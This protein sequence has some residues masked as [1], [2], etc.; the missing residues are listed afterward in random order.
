VTAPGSSFQAIFNV[1]ALIRGVHSLTAFYSGDSN[2]SASWSTALSQ[3]V[4][5]QP[6]TVNLTSAPSM[7]S[8]GQS[9][10][11]TA[12]VAPFA[13]TLAP[14]GTVTFYDGATAIGTAA[15]AGAVSGSVPAVLTFAALSVGSH[16][17]SATYSG[18]NNFSS[19]N[20]NT[21]TQT[22]NQ[23]SSNTTLA[24]S[25]N[26][27]ALCQSAMFTATVTPAGSGGG[28]PTGAV[29]FYNGGTTLGTSSLSG[30]VATYSTASLPQGSNSISA[31]YAG[32]GNFLSGA[33]N[34]LTQ[35]VNAA[36]NWVMTAA[37]AAPDPQQGVRLPVGRA[38]FSPLSGT[39]FRSLAIDSNQH[40]F[41]GCGGFGGSCGCSG[42]CGCGGCGNDN[43][44]AGSVPLALVY[45][46]GTVN[47]RPIFLVNLA[48]D[49]CASVPSQIQSQLTWN[50]VPQG[51]NTFGTPGH[52]AGDVYAV[53]QQVGSAVSASDLY[54]WSV[55]VKA[56]VGTVV[57]DRTASG[58]SPVVVNTSSPFGAGWA[59]G[60]SWSLLIK[61]AG[62]VIVDNNTGGARYFTGTGPTY[63]S[64]AND[65]GSLI[66]NGDG[67]YT[68]TAKNQTKTNFDSAGRMTGQVDPHGLTQSL[69]YSGNLLTTVTGCDGGVATFS[70]N[71]SNLLTSVQEP[72]GRYLTLSYDA[73][74]NL[75]SFLDAA[76][77]PHTFAYDSSHRLVNEKVGPLNV[78]YTYSSGNSTLTQINR[79]LGTTLAVA[80]AAAQGLGASTAINASAAVAA[81]TDGL[82]HT[83][84]YAFDSLGRQTQLQTADA[85]L[86]T[87]TLDA[88]GNPTTYADQRGRV[89]TYVYNTAEDLTQV[90]YPD[91]TFATYQYETTFHQK[92]QCQDALGRL[93]TFSYD[94]MTGDL[95]TK[96]DA[97][98][99]VTTYTW[100]SGLKQTT[101]DALGHVTTMQWDSAKRRQ[102][103]LIDA[104]SHV[105]T[106]GYDGA[107]N[108]TTVQDAL[109]HVTT[110]S[111]DGNRRV[112]TRTNALGGATTYAYDAVGDLSSW[113]DPLGRTTSFGYDQRG[114]PTT[115][116]EAVGTAQQRT[117]TTTYDAAGN[118]LYTTD[119]LGDVTSYA[120]DALNR[121]TAKID[122]YGTSLQRT[123]TMVY[124]LAGNILSRIDPRGTTTSYGYDS[125]NRQ[126]QQIDAY[127]AAAQRTTTMAHDA[128]GNVTSVTNPRGT[129][130][131]FAYDADNR[132]TRRLEAYGTSLQRTTT[133]AYDA[134][135]NVQSVT[136]PTATTSYAYDPLNR[137]TQTIDG[138]GSSVQRTTTTAYDAVGNM[139][140][141]VNPRGYTTSYGYDA[142]NR[143]IQ[144]LDA[145]GTGLQRT[146]TTT[147]DA[148]GNL[149]S[150]TNGVGEVTSFAYDALNR[151]TAQL[152]GYGTSLQRTTTTAYDADDNVTATMDPLGYRTTYSY[153]ALNRRVTMRDAGGGV[154]TTAYDADDNLTAQTDPLGHTTT[155]AYDVLNRK[156][157]TTDARGGI[158]TLVY[159]PNNNLVS[160]TDPVSNLTQW[161]YD[162]LDRKLKE[163]D[164]LSYGATYAYDAADRLTSAT[165]RNGQRLAYR[166]DA[167]NRETGETWYNA[168]GTSIN[169]LT[170]TYDPNNN[171]LTA[172]NATATNT[173]AYDALD[174]KTT[175]Q[176]PFGAFLT[177]AYDAADNRTLMQ[178]SLGAN[179]TRVYDVLN[180][181]T[182]MM[183]G[184]TGQ[185]PLREDFTYTALDRTATQTRYS[186][187][188]GTTTIGDSTYGY[189]AVARLTNLQHQN[190]AGANIANYTNTYDLASRITSE[191]LNGAAPTTY[192]YD[193]TNELTSDGVTSYSY[194]LNGNRTMTGYMTGAANELTSDGTWN[195]YYDPNGNRTSSRNISTSETWQFGYDNRNRLTTAQDVTSAG[196]QTQATY[197][198]DAVGKRIEKD[199]GSGGVTTVT[200]F[201][202]DG[203]EIWADLNSSNTLMTR[204]VR[205]DRVL[206][207][208][209][210]ISGGGTAAWIQ[211]DRLGTVRHV[212]DATGAV[213]DT[214]T[215]DGYGNITN[216]T[217]AANGGVYKY[218][219]YRLDSESGWYRPD[220][221]TARYYGP[222]AGTWNGRDAL[223]LFVKA[224]NQYFYIG[225]MPTKATDASGEQPSPI[226]KVQFE[227]AAAGGECTGPDKNEFYKKCWEYVRDKII[228]EAIKEQPGGKE[229]LE[230]F[231]WVGCRT[232]TKKDLDPGELVKK[233]IGLLCKFIP[234]NHFCDLFKVGKFLEACAAAIVTGVADVVIPDNLKELAEGFEGVDCAD[235]IYEA[236]CIRCCVAKYGLG[237][238]PNML[239]S[240]CIEKAGCHDKT[241]GAHL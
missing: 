103:A 113:I 135:G 99:N 11:F 43:C 139:L 40:P 211:P 169:T 192:A 12:S 17:I 97:L 94:A 125:R 108:Q 21:I 31:A 52:S 203:R 228:E 76:G 117:T 96:K 127:G 116:T 44:H 39:L 120:Y 239:P 150:A 53:P 155:Y 60:G 41:C 175:A 14:T 218:A 102:T 204:Y 28:T 212:V 148:V 168:A 163:T 193:A 220:P 232:S 160:L 181:T 107:G 109:G 114:L 235:L 136:S 105:T 128:V 191:T 10:T 70:Y 50:G 170:F 208:L 162:A 46:S 188:A 194:D 179:T 15:C 201:A 227:L 174:R 140:S 134:V 154:A 186:N 132:P 200:R 47:V 123:A 236:A 68:Y 213:L 82:G 65:Q 166:Y 145:Y 62:I 84:S 4:N 184:G 73:Q 205:G 187:L 20:S 112:V 66:K 89:T 56:T 141:A 27:S 131:S 146:L 167:L 38:E 91:G 100:S 106:Y 23:A 19:A 234:K 206:E 199:V 161:L 173:M 156:T 1:S 104:L 48:S 90:A 42:A 229:V 118:V 189:D 8:Y 172:A 119:P 224:T 197:V 30:G 61:S 55:E 72:G 29:T 222:A 33:S 178:D 85:A 130:T 124:D 149:L 81:L 13:G 238:D 157:L 71:A 176:D 214:I 217:G 190:G 180:R 83:T 54:S 159:D 88:A 26:P 183:F 164:P 3:T 129:V 77:G 115:K 195:Y 185:T 36:V 182:T 58:V 142:L 59:L 92:T 226:I 64:P 74:S 51:W 198:Y 137:T 34:T 25:V 147:Y 7:S 210:R 110:T 223:W 45:S 80:A 153:D 216:E 5:Q 22:V 202:Y 230:L 196:L 93:T 98:G 87:W 79:G 2:Y 126:I 101:T 121:A 144:R 57:Y 6:P 158:V 171:L 32:D 16:S 165:D 67:S 231:E 209:A 86:Q 69:G 111:Y 18:D 219:G 133:T 225:N 221:T 152:D 138:Y 37:A 240:D 177:Y 233:C 151:A 241:K 24:A 9:V 207:L 122:A 215:Y 49:F 143:R 95:L 35:T 237:I 63:T 75:T 78:T